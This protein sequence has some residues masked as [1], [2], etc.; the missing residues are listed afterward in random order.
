VRNPRQ[1]FEPPHIVLISN[2]GSRESE[3]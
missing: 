1:I 2:P 3:E